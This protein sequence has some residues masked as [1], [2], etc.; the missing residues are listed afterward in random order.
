MRTCRYRLCAPTDHRLERERGLGDRALSESTVWLL[1]TTSGLED[2]EVATSPAATTT[3]QP[4]RHGA[5]RLESDLRLVY[6]LVNPTGRSPCDC[7]RE[8]DLVPIV[9]SMHSR[10]VA[11]RRAN[12]MALY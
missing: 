11:T 9:K 6:H 4:R 1:T 7:A 8:V 2:S 3:T 10:L 12:R 5:Q